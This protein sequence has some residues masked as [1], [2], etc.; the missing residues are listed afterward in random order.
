VNA[1][2]EFLNYAATL[3]GF[4]ACWAEPAPLPRFGLYWPG[5]TPASLDDLRVTWQA[6]RAVAAI[7]FYRALVQAANLAAVDGLISALDEAGLN[8]LPIYTQSLKE[9]LAAATV[10]ELLDEF[11]LG[12]L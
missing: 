11:Q 10:A 5:A 3:A 7:V 9:P 8:A 4:E 1:P 6:G 12:T 2:G